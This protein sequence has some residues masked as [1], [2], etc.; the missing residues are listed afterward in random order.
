MRHSH[1]PYNLLALF[2]AHIWWHDLW[3][4]ETQNCLHF[5]EEARPNSERA[6]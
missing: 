2:L 1:K 4:L 6:T 3:V 5:H